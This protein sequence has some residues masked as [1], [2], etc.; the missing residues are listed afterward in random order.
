MHVALG[1]GAWML[2]VLGWP[3]VAG[4]CAF[5]LLFN[6]FLLHRLPWTRELQRPGD[7]GGRS[8]LVLYPLVL[9]ALVLVFRTDHAP[10]QAGWV[11]LALGD[12]LAPLAGTLLPGPKWPWNRSKSVAGT[13]AAFTVAWAALSTLICPWEAAV[14]MAAGALADSAPGVVDDNLSIPVAAATAA[15]LLGG[16]S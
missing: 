8:G 12:G 2:P 13:A 16:L 3:A 11:A 7:G 1:S 10:V 6:L 9:L 5:G 14:C 15:A 4:L